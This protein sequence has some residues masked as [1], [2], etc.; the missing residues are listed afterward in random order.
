MII[1]NI[2]SF[3]NLYTAN[4]IVATKQ[5]G[6]VSRTQKAKSFQDEMMLSK[7]A[8]SFRE[9]INKIHS[10]SDVR[11]NKVEEYTQKIADGSYNVGSENI[12]AS[13]LRF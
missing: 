11:Q 5:S 9:M 1:N 8:I 7:E 2:N 13:I 4:A 6:N 10:E 3:S 12:A